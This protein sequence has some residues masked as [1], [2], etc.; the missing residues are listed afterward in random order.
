MLCEEKSKRK[1]LNFNN[2]KIAENDKHA[3]WNNNDPIIEIEWKYQ[4]KSYVIV[5][6]KDQTL[7]S[8]PRSKYSQFSFQKKDKNNEF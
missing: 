4:V 7:G 3:N 1:Q 5:H 6:N 8:R 2:C